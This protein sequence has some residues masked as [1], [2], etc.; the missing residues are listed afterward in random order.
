MRSLIRWN[1]RS[2]VETTDPFDALEQMVDEMWNSWPFSTSRRAEGSRTLLRPAMD[3]VEN[4]TEVILRLDLPGLKP[5]DVNVSI[6]D[7][8]LTISGQIGD[9]IERDGDRYHYRERRSGSFERSIRLPNTVDT[10][11]VDAT[12]E[13]GVLNITLPKLAQAQP[14]RINVKASNGK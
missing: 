3:V 8:V 13:S 5:D 4:D 7:H 12:F 10:E 14:K 2:E 1:P 6:D 11:N 9:T